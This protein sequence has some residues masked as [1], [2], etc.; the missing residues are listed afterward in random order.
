[1]MWKINKLANEQ[2]F[3]L[4]ELIIVVVILGILAAVGIPKF[5]NNRLDAWAS[6]CKANRASLDD[7]IERYKFDRSSYPTASTF[8]TDLVNGEYIKK[9]FNCPATGSNNYSMNASGVVSCGNTAA[10]A[11]YSGKKHVE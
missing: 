10:T 4:I 6:T 1:M 3:T 11:D 5:L 2:G 9:V 7:A 8:Q